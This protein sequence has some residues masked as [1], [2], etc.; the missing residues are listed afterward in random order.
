[1]KKL[2]IFARQLPAQKR[3]VNLNKIVSEALYFLEVHCQKEGIELTSI[4]STDI[5]D[6]VL[7]SSQIQQV[8]VNLVVNAIHAMPKGGVI[9]V[10]TEKHKNQVSL[11]VQDTGVG[12]SKEVIEQIFMPF[13]TTKEIG[14]GTG[15]GLAVVH[16]IVAN[17]RGTIDVKSKI[18]H[19]TRF[20]VKLSLDN[21]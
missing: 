20:E 9:T 7:D 12:M 11:I 14:Q 19:G 10:K 13:F 2:L 1:M 4:L 15:L 16:G 17:H 3:S 18:G 5:T 6:M 8:L 21:T